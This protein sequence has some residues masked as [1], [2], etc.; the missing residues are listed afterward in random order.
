[1]PFSLPADYGT[2]GNRKDIVFHDQ[3]SGVFSNGDAF[4]QVSLGT[5]VQVGKRL[6]SSSFPCFSQKERWSPMAVCS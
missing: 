3:A 1:M 4:E 6:A 2:S 5:L